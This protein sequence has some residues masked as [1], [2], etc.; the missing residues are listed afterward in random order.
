MLLVPFLEANTAEEEEPLLVQLLEEHVKPVVKNILRLRLYSGGSERDFLAED[1][2]EAYEEIQLSL[3]KRLRGCKSQ[4]DNSVAS[5][6]K[7]VAMVAHNA[8]D[9]YF[10]KKFPRR[11]NLKDSIRYC[12]I[13]DSNFVL[14]QDE[15]KGWMASLAFIANPAAT[16][17]RALPANEVVELLARKLPGIDLHRL[18]LPDVITVVLET[19][20]TPIDLD[21]LTAVV[22]KVRDIEDIPAASLD[23]EGQ[24]LSERIPSSEASPAALAEYHEVLKQLWDEIKRLP[25][26]HRVALLCNLRD[27]QGVNVIMLFPVTGVATFEELADVLELSVSDFEMLWARLPLDDASL[28]EFLGVTR[29]Q[30]INLRR[31]ARD[32]LRRRLD[33]LSTR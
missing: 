31:N 6:R 2:E 29:Q 18:D 20:P 10:R 17:G 13:T 27:Q 21:V 5:L 7:Y 14:W 15:N 28:A 22:A 26:R 12:L 30:V 11:R 25:R 24:A 9:D 3:L 4:P 16:N 19:H 23:E 8:C 1:F 33:G 32:R